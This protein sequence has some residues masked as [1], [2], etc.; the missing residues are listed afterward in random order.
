MHRRYAILLSALA[1]AGAMSPAAAQVAGG[2]AGARAMASAGI[3]QPAAIAS[4]QDLMFVVSTTTT[5]AATLAT[6]TA[7]SSTSSGAT[8]RT[9]SG[10]PAR[11]APLLA[12][13]GAGLPVPARASFV[14]VGDA[15][16][17]ISVTVPETIDLQ[18][19]GGAETARLVT[20]TSVTDGP[21]F[22]GGNFASAGTLSF[23]VGGQV[24]LASAV[25]SG[26]YNGILAVVAQYN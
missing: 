14:V 5:L 20:D 26:T 6:A 4:S 8:A 1:V 13:G 7:V 9:N 25:T 15:G 23:D 22:L 12:V 19:T 24:T 16:Q 10:N 2:F 18:R 17:S 21:Q 11:L 3:E